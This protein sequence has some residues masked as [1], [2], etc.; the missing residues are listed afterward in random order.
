[1][2]VIIRAANPAHQAI[3]QAAAD[4]T[5]LPL[6][7][8]FRSVV[9]D[10]R[11]VKC[12]SGC[13]ALHWAAGINQVHVIR[14]LLLQ[15]ES[16]QYVDLA[17][18]KKY[19]A[20]GRTPLHYAARNGCLEAAHC[21]MEEFAAHPNPCAKHGVTP[22]HLACFQ[23]QLPMIQY[24]LNRNEKEATD[25][26]FL[27]N[28]C[29]C[30]VLHWL[31]ICPASRAGPPG[32][33]DLIPTAEWLATEL[34]RR[35]PAR[36]DLWHA[37]Q[38]QGHTVL[39]KAAWL[40]HYAL[41]QY[42]HERHDVWDDR[43][44][45]AGNYAVTVAEMARHADGGRTVHY[46]RTHCSRAAAHSCFLLGLPDLAAAQDP[47]QLR[48]AYHH[49]ARQYHPDRQPRACFTLEKTNEPS[50]DGIR[51]DDSAT[52]V[53]FDAIYKAYYHLS[54]EGGRGQQCNAA[55]QLKLLLPPI[56]SNEENSVLI[57]PRCDDTLDASADDCFKARLIV[58]LKEYG[59]KGLDVSNLKK[60]WRQVWR[61]EAFPDTGRRSLTQ[62]IQHTAGD[63][64]DVL[65]VNPCGYRVFVRTAHAA[66]GGAE[67]TDHRL[68]RNYCDTDSASK[69]EKLGE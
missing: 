1:M 19:P 67:R 24:L 62:W 69:V 40:G 17:I 49:R 28:D 42:L 55:H 59:N 46:L 34:R 41:I 56:A 25:T 26:L 57:H 35:G 47:V 7:Q 14:Y 3:L 52:E 18:E 58:V 11:D 30:N 54:V 29:G 65:R 15:P 12:T 60:K 63:V 9:E 20:A 61:G 21:L 51:E 22:L 10:W 4:G 64:V 5:L 23:N 31:A 39:H 32:G 66:P 36:E 33:V 50:D 53:T 37:V 45:H 68:A 13:T 2:P 6:Q 16:S 8:R 44:D 48:R 27:T 38:T 43:P